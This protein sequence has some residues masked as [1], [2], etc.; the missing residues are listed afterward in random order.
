MSGKRLEKIKR[1]PGF[2]KAYFLQPKSTAWISGCSSSL[3]IFQ[4]CKYEILRSLHLF[5]QWGPR[6]PWLCQTPPVRS[7]LKSHTFGCGSKMVWVKNTGY[8]K[9]P[10]GK[11]K[12]PLKPVVPVGVFFL[13]H[14]HHKMILGISCSPRSHLKWLF[15]HLFLFLPSPNTTAECRSKAQHPELRWNQVLG[16]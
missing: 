12:N 5:L 16:R 10:I 2:P 7:V 9:N 11:R 13:T 14:S 4:S 6:Y 15:F 8:L 3:F 1:V